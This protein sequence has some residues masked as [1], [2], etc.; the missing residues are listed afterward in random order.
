MGTTESLTVTGQSPI[1][2]PAAPT[3][4]APSAEKPAESIAPFS[5]P[6]QRTAQFAPSEI[7][8]PDGAGRW[9]IVNGQ[10]QRWSPQDE[11]WQPAALPSQALVAGHAPSASVAWFVGKGGAIFVTSDGTSFEQVSFITTADLVAV[12]AIDDRQA[13]VTTSDGRQ[14]RTADRGASWE[15]P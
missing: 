5:S 4:P 8:S 6:Q 14:F 11:A 3:P 9:R 2:A 15:R 10:V 13:T 7:V 12:T 1:V